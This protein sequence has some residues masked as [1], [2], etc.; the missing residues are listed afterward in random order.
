MGLASAADGAVWFGLVEDGDIRIF[1]I[2][3]DQWSIRPAGEVG[4]QAG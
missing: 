1:T 4:V 3:T 2:Q